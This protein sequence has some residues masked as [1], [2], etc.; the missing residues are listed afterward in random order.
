MMVTGAQS[1]AAEKLMS[2]LCGA[3]GPLLKAEWGS[4][5]SVLTLAPPEKRLGSFFKNT[6]SLVFPQTIQ[7]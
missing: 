7:S 4:P 5:P 1:P 2:Q 3:A 6:H